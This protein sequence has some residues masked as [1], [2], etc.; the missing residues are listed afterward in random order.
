ME[1]S[2]RLVAAFIDAISLDEFEVDELRI[3]VCGFSNGAAW[4]PGSPSI[5]PRRAPRSRAP[6]AG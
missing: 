2:D 1:R 6:A 4:P 3:Y 5:T